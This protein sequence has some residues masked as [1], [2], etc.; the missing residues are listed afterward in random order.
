MSLMAKLSQ[1][2]NDDSDSIRDAIIDNVC[3]LISSRAP[4]W[5]ENL[6]IDYLQGSIAFLGVRN[7]SRTQ[8]KTNSDVILEDINQLIDLYEPRLS[9]V[10]V[11]IFEDEKHAN[12]LHIQISAIMFS[13]LGEESVI[14]D[15]FL[16]LSSSR[17]V[18]RKSNFV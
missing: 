9:H 12:H 10:T 11:E 8:S 4:I 3:G 16:D 6:D 1:R 17:L 5:T 18:V 2:W 15:S 13:E 7:L 14:F